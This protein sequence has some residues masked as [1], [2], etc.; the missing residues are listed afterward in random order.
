[1]KKT[2]ISNLLQSISVLATL[3]VVVNG[4]YSTILKQKLTNY[5]I[6]YILYFANSIVKKKKKKKKKKRKKNP[7]L[8]SKAKNSNLM[9]SSSM[10]RKKSLWIMLARIA[11]AEIND[12]TRRK[13]EWCHL[14]NC[15]SSHCIAI[16]VPLK[17]KMIKSD[18][19][20]VAKGSNLI[21]IARERRGNK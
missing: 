1:M 15:V 18:C 11:V 7:N 9:S 14:W 4:N 3:R 19:Q 16:Y 6:Y 17:K 8:T 21:F 2:N 13:K 5:S 12:G 20:S 10:F